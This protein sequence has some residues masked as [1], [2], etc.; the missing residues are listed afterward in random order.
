MNQRK[1]G[2]LPQN[3]DGNPINLFIPVGWS[4]EGHQETF[5]SDHTQPYVQPIFSAQPHQVYPNMPANRT[6]GYLN[7]LN[8]Y[9]PQPIRFMPCSVYKNGE[10]QE[11]IHMGLESQ[12]PAN[13]CFPTPSIHIPDYHTF[14]MNDLSNEQPCRPKSDEESATTGLIS[15][16]LQES[17]TS[18]VTYCDTTRQTRSKYTKKQLDILENEFKK[19]NFIDRE[20]IKKLIKSL[21]LEKR[22]IMIWFQNRRGKQKRLDQLS[23]RKS[24][25]THQ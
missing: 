4:N 2:S 6:S 15:N 24:H 23:E 25:Q 9:Q 8:H 19:N 1:K 14:S 13:F 16:K 10:P 17:S 11:I 18:T 5:N 21:N 7:N 12:Y 3:T 22:Q 20:R